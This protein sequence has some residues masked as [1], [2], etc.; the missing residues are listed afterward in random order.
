MT[1]IHL[2]VEGDRKT[3]PARLGRRKCPTYALNPDQA[4]C[5]NC[6]TRELD[7]CPQ[8][9]DPLKLNISGFTIED[10][11]INLEEPRDPALLED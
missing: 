6:E 8:G 10:G 3:K 4:P 2:W 11:L 9:L 1:E 5:N 7:E